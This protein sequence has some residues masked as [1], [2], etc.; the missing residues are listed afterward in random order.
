MPADYARHNL[1]RLQ[2]AGAA[3]GSD[4]SA[5][6][7]AAYLAHHLGPGDAVRFLGKGLSSARAETLLAAQVGR[8]A[9][10]SRIAAAGEPA[11]AHRVWLTAYVDRHIRPEKFL[12]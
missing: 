12:A 1:D 6:A 4:V 3:V 10:T 8:S 7:K 11:H 2:R 5:L 9:A